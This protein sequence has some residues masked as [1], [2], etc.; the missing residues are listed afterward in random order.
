MDSPHSKPSIVNRL[1]SG[2]KEKTAQ[3]A[4]SKLQK[5][6]QDEVP[7]ESILGFVA[8]AVR[9]GAQRLDVRIQANDLILT[10]DG[11]PLNDAQ[12]SQLHRGI[13]SLPELSKGFRLHLGKDEGQIELHMITEIGMSVAKY[14]GFA[15]PIVGQADLSD[16]KLSKMTTRVILKGSGN[17]RRVNQAMGNELPEVS[18][19]RKRCFLA[20]IDIVVAGRSID[21]YTR[22]PESLI[23]GSGIQREYH[24]TLSQLA[25]TPSQG[26]AVDLSH[27]SADLSAIQAGICGI[28]RTPADAGWYHLVNGIARPIPDVSWLSRTW[29]YLSLAPNAVKEQLEAE[30]LYL[31]K[32]LTGRLF[33]GIQEKLSDRAEEALSFLEQN[34]ST[35]NE[36][37][38]SSVD[39][40]RVFLTL[41]EQLSPSSDPRVLTNRLELASSLEAS[42][43]I[44]ESE[45][46]YA[47]VL[48]VWESE[49]LNHFDKY[50]FEEGA[51]LW[52][53]ALSL[54]EK[55]GTDQ[56]DLAD[57][58]LRLAEIGRDQ[59]LGFAE[60]A[61]RRCLQ[62][63]RSCGVQN[64]E[65]EYKVLLGLAQVL[66][67]NRVLTESLKLAEEAQETMMELNEGRETKQ[68]VPI[69]RLQAEIYDLQNDYGRSTEFE[70]KAMLLKFKR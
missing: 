18:L 1:V 14:K 53:R 35:L 39:Q 44:E 64:K 52:Q 42:G 61:Y 56:D 6:F 24:Q 32:E 47:E 25:S 48:P 36:A 69:L 49:A 26:I 59:R 30:I 50:R 12:A 4:E 23:T 22:L 55:L 21:R 9:L 46:L 29:G 13:Q 40:D 3:L 37:G 8:S 2:F 38:H 17:Y 19:I 41:R 16:L 7:V 28:A 58:Y 66:K 43:N 65:R 60:Q 51:A 15:T 67:K 45:K 5:T 54:R 62:L 33:E 34:R 31:A 27:L 68:L 11:A 20:P 57:K 63:V 70:Q 10:H